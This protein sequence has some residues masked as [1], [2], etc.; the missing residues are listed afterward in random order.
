MVLYFTSAISNMALANSCLIVLS[1]HCGFR[2]RPL[3]EL[4]DSTGNRGPSIP[5][6]LISSNIALRKHL[7]FT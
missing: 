3:I 7:V 6:Q 5:C 2:I 4:Y 1:S